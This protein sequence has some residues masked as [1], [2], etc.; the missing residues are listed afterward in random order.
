MGVQQMT[1]EQMRAAV[2]AAEMAGVRVAAHAHGTAG[3]K[4]AVR[5][6]VHSI[7][8]GSRL[9]REAIRMMKDW[10][11]YLVPTR[12]VAKRAA[13]AARAGQL[14][15]IMA[16]KALQIVDDHR[17]SFRRAVEAGVKIAFGSDTPGAPR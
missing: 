12:L 8:H 2:E 7:E 3:I 10:G 17:A 16:E 5:A 4:A 6:G 13:E 9:D 1:E 14:P 15:P 11:T